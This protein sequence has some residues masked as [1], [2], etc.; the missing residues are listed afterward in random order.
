[1]KPLA[2][3]IELIELVKALRERNGFK[4]VNLADAIG[5]DRSTYSRMECGELGFT[6][7]QFKI[8]ANALKTNQ[9]QL[10]FLVDSKGDKQ[11]YNTTLSTILIKTIKMLEGKAN[12]IEFSEEE[13]FFVIN[14]IKKKYEEMWLNS[15]DLREGNVKF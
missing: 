7:G 1:M 12:E 13:L 6:P 10:Y 8:M 5:V 3:D 4:H 15:P 2:Y 9:Y 14:L 11:F